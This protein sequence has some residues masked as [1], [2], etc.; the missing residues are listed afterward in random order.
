MKYY[1]VI[2]TNVLVSALFSAD[3][4]PGRI[5]LEALDGCII[6]LINDEIIAEY[7]DVLY[8]RKFHFEWSAVKV[9][10]DSMIKRGIPVDAGPV[11]DFIPDP[12]DVV[13]YA[14]VME[15][16]KIDNA[17]LVTGNSKHF[18]QKPFV[19]TPREMLE[20]IEENQ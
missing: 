9:L 15:Q 10:I 1:A 18:P 7:N 2:D 11:S 17:Y 8:R 19:V 3:S 14:V 20:I 4:V 5:T 16:R 6:P 12:K 13:F